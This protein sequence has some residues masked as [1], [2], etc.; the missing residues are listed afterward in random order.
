MYKL[1]SSYERQPAAEGLVDSGKTC[2]RISRTDGRRV[3][4][5]F[6]QRTLRNKTDNNIDVLK[7]L[8]VYLFISFE[9]V[10]CGLKV[11]TSWREQN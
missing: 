1:Q 11:N 10:A 9:A 6:R 3:R 2:S 7:K 4:K 8:I 5:T